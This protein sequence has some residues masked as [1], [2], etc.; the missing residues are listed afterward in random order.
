LWTPR[1][2]GASQHREI[3]CRRHKERECFGLV[4]FVEPEHGFEVV[5]GMD[6]VKK[7]L[8]LPEELD[9]RLRQLRI[10][11]GNRH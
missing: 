3:P 8:T 1:Q 7:D 6:E 4:E 2:A 5:G 10:V 11:V 9:L